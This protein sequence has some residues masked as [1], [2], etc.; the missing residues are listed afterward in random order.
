MAE[1]DPSYISASSSTETDSDIARKKSENSKQTINKLPP[2]L[3]T[4]IFAI[5]DEEKRNK[6]LHYHRYYGFQDL[7]IQICSHWRDVAINDPS[8]WTYIY[9]SRAPPLPHAL[10]YLER[11][12][13]SNR[14]IVD[15]ELRRHYVSSLS[16]SDRPIDGIRTAF[17]Y[18]F[19]NGVTT[20]RWG[21]L[22]LCARRPNLLFELI[23]IMHTLALPALRFL[24]VRRENLPDLRADMEDVGLDLD[25]ALIGRSLFTSDLQ[26]PCLRNAGF[27]RL[28]SLYL[29]SRP[30]SLVT[31]LTD[32]MICPGIGPVSLSALYKTISSNLQLRSL[33][34]GPGAFGPRD[35]ETSSLRVYLPSLRTFSLDFTEPSWGLVIIKMVEAPFLER[36]RL[37]QVGA[38]SS[39]NIVQYITTGALNDRV[40]DSAL[41]VGDSQPLAP[42]CIY[43]ELKYLDVQH[44]SVS[45]LPMFRAM[46]STFRSVI[47]VSVPP[48]MLYLL[49]IAPWVMPDLTCICHDLPNE[50]DVLVEVLHSR[51]MADHLAP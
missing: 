38:W 46:L 17:N 31:S 4:R 27:E 40:P 10:L 3:L 22:M 14:L 50:V 39:V 26:V 33:V 24:S 35:L 7:A 20:D 19:L 18:M 25:L 43:P 41:A 28:P 15:I 30:Q 23:E 42:S 13:S 29:F 2:E 36:L 8:L 44:L 11:S 5:G 6:R 34:L 16:S 12:G 32:L 48:G 51:A 1:H 21:S 45:D 49:G 47:Q 37:V 9:I